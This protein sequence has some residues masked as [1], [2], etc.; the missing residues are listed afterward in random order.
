MKTTS[1]FAFIAIAGVLLA[2]LCEPCPHHS[3]SQIP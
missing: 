1:Q 2:V 3:Q